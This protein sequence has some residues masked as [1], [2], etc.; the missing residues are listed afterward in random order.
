MLAGAALGASMILHLS[1]SL[2]WPLVV[3]AVPVIS[4]TAPWARDPLAVQR[5]A[6]VARQGGY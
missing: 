1:R 4:T 6:G 5:R 3:A 2:V